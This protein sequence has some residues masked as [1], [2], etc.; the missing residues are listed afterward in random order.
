MR[1]GKRLVW[2]MQG[3]WYGRDA[4]GPG[5]KLCNME[6]QYSCATSIP[7][8]TIGTGLDRI[9]SLFEID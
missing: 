9:G 2:D 5:T 7:R 8:I 1:R 4:E 3:A 6:K